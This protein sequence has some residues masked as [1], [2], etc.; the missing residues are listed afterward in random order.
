M[1]GDSI[2]DFQKRFIEL[3]RSNLPTWSPA[4]RFDHFYRLAV[5]TR[6]PASEVGKLLRLDD[7]LSLV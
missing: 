7:A 5:N 3:R 6:T 4:A 2:P 1:T